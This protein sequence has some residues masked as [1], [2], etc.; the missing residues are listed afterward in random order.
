MITI[1]G[2]VRNPAKTF[3]ERLSAEIHEQ[4]DG[5]IRQ[6]QIGQQLFGMEWRK[7]LNGLHFDD[8]L[9]VHEKVNSEAF[10]KRKAVKDNRQRL[11]P[12]DEQAT[13]FQSLCEKRFIDGLENPRA[14]ILMEMKAAVDRSRDDVLNI[15]QLASRLPSSSRLRVKN[16]SSGPHFDTGAVDAERFQ[17]RLDD[18]GRV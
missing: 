15:S 8:E 2:P 10:R 9:L 12:L 6:A 7:P 1:D 16:F 17:H 5:L 11:L 3:L 18:V 13:P 14:K 4:P